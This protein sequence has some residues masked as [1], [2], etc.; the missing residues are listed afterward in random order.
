M[1]TVVITYDKCKGIMRMQY[2]RN[3]NQRFDNDPLRTDAVCMKVREHLELVFSPAQLNEESVL[4]RF[5]YI[6]SISKAED[7]RWYTLPIGEFSPINL[8]P[9]CFFCAD[10]T[11]N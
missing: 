6:S 3:T 8:I 4:G 11:Y 5:I 2:A 9:C 1:D 7:S 10:F